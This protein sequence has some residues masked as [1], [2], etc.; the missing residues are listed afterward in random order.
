MNKDTLRQISEESRKTRSEKRVL[1]N[2]VKKLSRSETEIIKRLR[3]QLA[4]LQEE[5][6]LRNA[7]ERFPLIAQ[8][9][10]YSGKTDIEVFDIGFRHTEGELPEREGFEPENPRKLKGA[11]KRFF[12]W[13]EKEGYGPSIQGN[14][15]DYFG[16]SPPS[17]TGLFIVIHLE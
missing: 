1:Q 2:E 8:I 9:A 11:G 14:R 12:E 13:L 6:E 10:A 17:S 3:E 7:Q 15:Q 4:Q 16:D 5:Q